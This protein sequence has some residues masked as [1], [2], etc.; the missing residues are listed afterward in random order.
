MV[1]RKALEKDAY[2]IAKVHV[3]S[4]KQTYKGIISD[5]ILSKLAVDERA[6][7]W[8]NSLGDPKN[9][10][11]VYVA[12]DEKGSVIGFASG[13]KNRSSENEYQGELYAIYLL[14]Q[15]HG[16]KI[17]FNLFKRIII[18]LYNKD[19]KSL[20]VWVLNDNPTIKFYKKLGGKPIKNKQI[21]FGND[22]LEEL[23]L[24]WTDTS[25][26]LK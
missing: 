16:N 2:S 21:K 12:E 22:N 5:D 4:W 20:M 18:E 24:G 10:D 14:N 7:L 26:I 3:E 6:K 1:I 23:A 11:I 15:Y 19:I 25:S 13:G 17:G 9:E 8:E